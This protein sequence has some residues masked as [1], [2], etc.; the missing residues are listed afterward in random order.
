MKFNLLTGKF[1]SNEARQLNPLVLAYIGDAVYEVFVRT[2]CIDINR[3]MLVHKLHLKVVSFVKARAQSEFMKEIEGLLTEEEMAIFKRGR[4]TKSS[5]PKNADVQEYR[6]AT[7]FEAV[8]GYLY[9]TEQSERLNYIL[10]QVIRVNS[11]KKQGD[12]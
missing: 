7:G 8:I 11:E 2:Y 10:E 4:N 5:V 12:D 3:D 1:S 9:I 6:L